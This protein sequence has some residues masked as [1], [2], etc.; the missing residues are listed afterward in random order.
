MKATNSDEK[1]VPINTNVVVSNISILVSWCSEWNRII[2]SDLRF[3]H[4]SDGKIRQHSDRHSIGLQMEINGVNSAFLI[5]QLFSK[6][7][8]SILADI[9]NRLS[10]KGGCQ[11]EFENLAGTHD[12]QHWVLDVFL[13]S[14][15]VSVSVS[16]RSYMVRHLRISNFSPLYNW[17]YTC[18]S[19]LL[20]H[21]VS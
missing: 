11:N 3:I 6:H 14:L 20:G 17:R 7:A 21:H 9:H 13:G 19:W 4:N 1:P 2:L 10:E 12:I 18:I 5:I 16:K 15:R 8:K